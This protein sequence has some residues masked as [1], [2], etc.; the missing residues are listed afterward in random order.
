[1]RV[2]GPGCILQAASIRERGIINGARAILLFLYV[3]PSTSLTTGLLE[4]DTIPMGTTSRSLI[5]SSTGRAG[6][7]GDGH[8]RRLHF[9]I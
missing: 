7:R 9:N 6:Q 5:C 1:M 3:P 4:H 2:G 8:H